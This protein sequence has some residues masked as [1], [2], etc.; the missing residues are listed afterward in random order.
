MINI[1]QLSWKLINQVCFHGGYS[2]LLLKETAKPLTLPEKNLLYTLTLGTINKQIFLSAVA[3]KYIDVKK[4]P[5]EI[6]SIFWLALYQ[7]HFLDHQPDYA[8]VNS[9][10]DLAKEVNPKFAGLVNKVLRKILSEGQT[11]FE[12]SFKNPEATYCVNHSF[13]V[14]LYRQIVQDYDEATARRV[15]A[16]SETFPEMDV[17]VN[18]LK[19][20]TSEFLNQYGRELIAKKV[21]ELNDGVVVH[22]VVVN[23]PIYQEGIVTIQDKASI[24]VGQLLNP[25][26]NSKVIDMCSAPGSKLTHLAALMENQGELEAVELQSNRIGLIEQNLQRMGVTIAR[27]HNLDA[28]EIKTREDFDYLLLDAPCSGFGV[29]RRKPEIKLHVKPRDLDSLVVLQGEL[30]DKAYELLKING[31]M[32]YSTCTV[33]YPE[34]AGQIQKFIAK[35]PDM[36]ILEERQLFGDEMN[37]DAFY[38]C[39]LQK[40][41]KPTK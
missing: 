18:T 5:N 22:K 2:N 28:R 31:V 36:K 23:D 25:T 12:V 30:L 11:A 16:W 6:Q 33:N 41:E 39:K 20:T 17:R 21:P 27:V 29:M 38:M 14:A 7:M 3:K 34:N 13:P 40:L 35:Y 1:R 15:V 32:V 37:S 4:T 8:I 9:A 24:L 26:P 10:V 19:L